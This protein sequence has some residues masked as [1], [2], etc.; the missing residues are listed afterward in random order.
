MAA[1]ADTPSVKAVFAAGPDQRAGGVDVAPFSI[2][3]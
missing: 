1:D 3:R 2:V